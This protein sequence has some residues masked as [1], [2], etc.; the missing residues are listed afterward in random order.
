MKLYD[1]YTP[2]TVEQ[3]RDILDKYLDEYPEN[4]N[5][6]VMLNNGSINL[7]AIY[8]VTARPTDCIIE[9]G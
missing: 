8:D 2:I 7:V 6:D 4:G 1:S 5:D 9:I 3:L